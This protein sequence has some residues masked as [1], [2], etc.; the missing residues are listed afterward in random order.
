MS[1]PR[2]FSWDEATKLRK[3]GLTLKAISKRLGV[4]YSA[5][6]FALNPEARAKSSARTVE[7]QRQGICPDCG[8]TATRFRGGK[9]CRCRACG[10]RAMATSAREAELHCSNCDEW[11]PDEEFPHNRGETVSRRGRHSLCRQCNTIVRRSYRERNRER[12]RA[13]DREYR[14]R[15]RLSIPA[16]DKT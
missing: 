8:A 6:W 9:Q 2:K 14:Q 1:P 5:V 16:G 12:E 7:W 11:K 15:K 4:S 3:S 10:I 13:Y